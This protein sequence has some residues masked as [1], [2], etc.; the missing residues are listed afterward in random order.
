MKGERLFS[1][2]GLKSFLRVSRCFLWR[3][4]WSPIQLLLHVERSLTFWLCRSRARRVWWLSFRRKSTATFV[5]VTSFLSSSR[6]LGRGKLYTVQF[7]R[8]GAV[9]LTFV[10]TPSC[11]AVL[12]NGFQFNDHDIRVQAVEQRSRLVYLRDL[13]C[14]VPDDA[15]R[16]ALRPF[17]EIHSIQKSVHDG[18][19]GLFDGSRVVKM[20]LGKD[21]PPVLCVAGFEFRVWYRRQ[22]NVVSSAESLVIVPRSAR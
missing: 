11:D 1:G 21:I 13:P 4:F 8:N 18:F 16:A 12:L 20:S 2:F 10:D 17:G 22:P 19:P 7:L 15:A 6:R 5:L 9:R 3:T 14:E